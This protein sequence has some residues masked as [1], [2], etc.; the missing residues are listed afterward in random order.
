MKISVCI[1]TYNG[2]KYILK[3]LLSI[4]NQLDEKD[5]VVLVDDASTDKTLILV[6]EIN[7]HRITIN[8]NDK[9]IGVVGT[10]NR[11]LSLAT[12][13]IIFLSDQDDEWE[14]HKVSFI[15]NIFLNED[16]DLIVHDASVYEE[17]IGDV[18]SLFELINSSSG[19]I[20]NIVSNSF[21]GCC[22]AFKTSVLTNVLPVPIKSGIYHDAW[23]GIF[24]HIN[25]CK[26]KYVKNRL[27]KFH[28]HSNNLT[29]LRRRG[30]NKII[31]E[32]FNLIIS[33]L[34]RLTFYSVRISK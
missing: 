5:E 20:K 22:M 34:Y 16:V 17:G 23:I 32:R 9:N 31:M 25:G 13:D 10:F 15:K 11:A 28:R 12:G 3:Q 7:D 29:T 33:I 8:I 1:A 26:V 21:T 30:I 19:V 6:R 24:A 27:I 2:E 14:L 4:L 18:G